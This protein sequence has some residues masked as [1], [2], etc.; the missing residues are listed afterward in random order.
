[1]NDIAQEVGLDYPH[2]SVRMFGVKPEDAYQ[3][4]IMIFLYF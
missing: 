4:S 1:M 3:I 2:L